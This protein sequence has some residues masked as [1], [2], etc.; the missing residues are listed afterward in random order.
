MERIFKY[1]A[2]YAMGGITV[3]RIPAIAKVLHVAPVDGI[4][5]AWA[6][7]NTSNLA[8]EESEIEYIDF[9]YVIGTGYYLQQDQSVFKYHSTHVFEWPLL[10]LHVFVNPNFMIQ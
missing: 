9:A 4:I 1:T 3:I 5:R 6:I 10:D 7:V 8:R 2:Q